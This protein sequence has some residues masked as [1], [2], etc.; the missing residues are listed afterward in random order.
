MLFE[1]S[2]DGVFAT[3]KLFGNFSSSFLGMICINN[4]L[5]II[6]AKINPTWLL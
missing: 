4:F 6:F 1:E 5:Y 3:V 2:T